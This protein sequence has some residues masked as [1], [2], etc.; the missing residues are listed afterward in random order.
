VTP[1]Q[2]KHSTK[3]GGSHAGKKK[4][5]ETAS[6]GEKGYSSINWG[7]SHF[8]LERKKGSA[9]R[10]KKG[11]EMKLEKKKSK[12]GGGSQGLLS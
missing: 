8:L 6:D 1:R 9:N 3:K 10:Q 12:R 5:S 4:K 2:R 11:E 7:T